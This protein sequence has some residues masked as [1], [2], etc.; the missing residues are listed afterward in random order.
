MNNW[1]IIQRR[2]R[3]QLNRKWV[4]QDRGDKIQFAFYLEWPEFQEAIGKM[5]LEF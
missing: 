3:K 1:A 5:Y 2:K 4:V